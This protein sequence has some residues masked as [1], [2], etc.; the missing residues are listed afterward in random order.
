M[1]ITVNLIQLVL[2]VEERQGSDIVSHTHGDI[3]I[4][5][6]DVFEGLGSFP[7]VHKIQLKP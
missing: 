4:E 2:S 5:Y 3:L 1:L 7:G 6:K